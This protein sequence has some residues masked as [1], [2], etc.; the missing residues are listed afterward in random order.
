MLRTP[1]FLTGAVIASKIP[2][3][4]PAVIAALVLHFVLDA[5][6]HKDTIGGHH[7]NVLNIL[8]NIGDVAV[9][10]ILFFVL[11]DPTIYAYAFLI[12]IISILPDIIEIPGLLW[13]KWFK[14]PIV[15]Q[16]H[17]WHT[18]VLK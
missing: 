12:G 2:S 9:A 7:I 10:L 1:H 4:W 14:L 6:P 13:P 15:K 3:F 8:L 5:I 17:H 18:E 11:I 16:F